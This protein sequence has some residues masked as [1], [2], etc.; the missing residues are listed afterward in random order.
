ML[1][2]LVPM[3]I[4]HIFLFLD[5]WV[6][7][8]LVIYHIYLWKVSIFLTVNNKCNKYCRVGWWQNIYP[9]HK[10]EPKTTTM[11]WICHV[12][13]LNSI[14]ERMV[15][16]IFTPTQSSHIYWS[17]CYDSFQRDF[18]SM[19]YG[20]GVI[21]QQSLLIHSPHWAFCFQTVL[22]TI[23]IKMFLHLYSVP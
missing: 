19:N 3:N 15:H 18:S 23:Y 7:F 14:G 10:Q 11:N 9:P 12:A 13:E 20:P 2:N 17:S 1:W 6:S 5:S 16:Y 21:F 22:C 8:L 4:V